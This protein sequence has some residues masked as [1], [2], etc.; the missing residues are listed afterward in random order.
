[1]GE[2]SRA[3]VRAIH[4]RHDISDRVWNKTEPL[5]SGRK[6]SWGAIAKD[7]RLL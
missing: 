6:C 2:R 3:Y 1:M 5:L 4:R 7:N